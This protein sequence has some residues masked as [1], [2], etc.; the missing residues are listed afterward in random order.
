M[1]ILYY[2]IK[3]IWYYKRVIKYSFIFGAIAFILSWLITYNIV[4]ALI[5]FIII[6][7]VTYIAKNQD[8]ANKIHG[9]KVEQ[10]AYN[11]IKQFIQSKDSSCDIKF[12]YNIGKSD[13]DIYIPKYSLAIDVKAYRK[14]DSRLYNSSGSYYKQLQHADRLIIWLPN[15]KNHVEHVNNK[16]TVICGEQPMYAY[17]LKHYLNK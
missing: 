7:L 5:S 4:Y 15:A 12:R 10:K 11:E 1:H 17:L 16:I 14:K 13:I 2:M 9:F 3:P 8:D 6:A